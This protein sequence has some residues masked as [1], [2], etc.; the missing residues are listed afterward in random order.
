MAGV[1]GRNTGNDRKM[2][3]NVSTIGW[4][5]LDIVCWWPVVS[6]L[7]ASQCFFKYFSIIPYDMEGS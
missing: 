5:D 6:W 2:M 3:K 4:H 1:F 7:N